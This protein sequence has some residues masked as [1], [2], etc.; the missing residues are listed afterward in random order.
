MGLKPGETIKLKL[1]D[2]RAACMM[3]LDTAVPI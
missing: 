2:V 1:S 3:L